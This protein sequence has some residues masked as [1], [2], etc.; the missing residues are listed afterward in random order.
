LDEVEG[1]NF[2]VP[3]LTIDLVVEPIE[4]R[5]RPSTP[6]CAKFSLNYTVIKAFQKGV[7]SHLS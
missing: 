6:Y 5:L 2:Y 7:V 3:K 4:E 1:I